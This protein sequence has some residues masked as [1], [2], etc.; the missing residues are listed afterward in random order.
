M[1]NCEINRRWE[2]TAARAL[3]RLLIERIHIL[4]L[5]FDDKSELGAKAR[6]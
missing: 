1:F 2:L 6:H 5:G 4:V 3:A